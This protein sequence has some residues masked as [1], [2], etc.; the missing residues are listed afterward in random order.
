MKAAY[1]TFIAQS[2]GIYLVSVPDLAI[3]TEGKNF[4]DAIDMARDAISLKVATLE[5]ENCAIPEPSDS[6]SAYKKAKKDTEIFDYTIGT[7]TFVDFD[8]VEYRKALNKKTVRRNV[9]IPQWL[10]IEA[11]KAHINVSKILQNALMKE[12]GL[13]YA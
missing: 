11:K 1:P 4:C 5:E 7:L 3:Y 12:L 13:H 9:A 10:D 2:D 8:T 6:K